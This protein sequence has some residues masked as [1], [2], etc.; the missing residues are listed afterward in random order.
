MT[1]GLSRFSQVA[2]LSIRNAASRCTNAVAV[3]DRLLIAPPQANRVA[4][5]PEALELPGQRST[6]PMAVSIPAAGSGRSRYRDFEVKL[7][8][9]TSRA[10]SAAARTYV[11]S[12]IS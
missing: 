2:S 12:S 7:P 4:P 1:C 5:A 8:L 9:G 3:G 6:Q 11:R 10:S